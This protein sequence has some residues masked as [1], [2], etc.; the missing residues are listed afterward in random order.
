MFPVWAESG[1]LL[2]LTPNR[3][4]ERLETAKAGNDREMLDFTNLQI[5]L[6]SSNR[7]LA[8][9]FYAKLQ[10]KLNET[11]PPLGLDLSGSQIRGTLDFKRL[12]LNVPLY[13][14][15]LSPLLSEEER[16]QLDRDRRR[17][18][19]LRQLSSTLLSDLEMPNAS[20]FQVT[21]FRGRLKLV[22]TR[23][24]D[25]VDWTNTFFLD[26]VD[27]LGTV[28][29]GGLNSA[30]ARFSKVFRFRNG[31]VAGSAIF[32][33]SI[34]FGQASFDRVRFGDF[35]SFSGV[36]F[37]A[38]AN[39]RQA[40]FEGRTDFERAKFVA[41]ADF[42][43]TNWCD[44]AI[45]SKTKFVESLYLTSAMFAESLNFRESQLTK[46]INLR[47][48]SL[49]GLADFSDAQFSPNAYLNISNLTF[50]SDRVQVIGN[51]GKIGEVISIPTLEGNENLLRNLVRNFRDLE[52]IED[53]N[54]VNYKRILLVQKDLL[55]RLRG[56]NINTAN[57]DRLQKTGFSEEQVVEIFKRRQEQPFAN[58]SEV[59]NLETIPLSTY[60][61]VRDRLIASP[62]I[63]W[64]KRIQLLL[65]LFAVT[66]LLA[67]SRYGTNFSLVFGVGAIEIAYFS[68]LFWLVDRFRRRLPNAIVPNQEESIYMLASGLTIV[69]LG[70][71]SVFQN[72]PQ[73]WLT[74][75]CLALVSLPI[76]GILLFRIYR[77]GRYHNL[78]DLSYF[79]E[80]GGF[81]QLRLMIGRLPIMPR[82]PF[83]RDRFEPILSD[84]RWN[85]LNYYD[86][87]LN[88]LLKFGFND[89]RL[90]DRYMP[91]LITALAWYQWGLGLL[92]VTLLLWTLSR[93]IPGL[94]LFLYLK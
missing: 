45:F 67:L 89:I 15:T 21:V 36:T 64:R 70:L 54:Q 90:R 30:E 32:R 31:Q 20:N 13:G 29:A 6:R 27:A 62:P 33:N 19:Q 41:T 76:P 37:E 50:D 79:V 48:A 66:I 55:K 93:T 71:T 84:R 42:S 68:L 38:T 82:F 56:T 51:P 1:E 16:Q 17:V 5:D 81:R 14:Q 44:R 11:N 49:M 57:P 53:A 35:V 61:K 22:G 74:L 69:G 9:L 73:P 39:F 58:L 8:D 18:S 80:D 4:S 10:R 52:Q 63:F 40:N 77:E 92:Y 88:N 85:W 65:K 83:F 59:L 46:P 87:S 75:T 72:S 43:Q 24:V 94:N 60:I 26:G 91:G 25:G 86:F 34:F 2:E 47:G 12:S 7:E 3:L 23:F 78:M 28:F